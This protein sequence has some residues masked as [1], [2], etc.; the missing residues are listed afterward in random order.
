MTAWISS[1]RE[2]AAARAPY[3][4]LTIAPLWERF[5]L[6]EGMLLA[7]NAAILWFVP[8]ARG[9]AVA[10]VALST[11]V[12]AVLYALNDLV[13]CEA[14][15][16]N[17]KKKQRLVEAFVEHRRGYA[18]F[19]AAAHAA[20][21]ALGLAIGLRVGL[22]VATMLA[23]NACYSLRAK[24]TPGLDL[25]VVAVWGG[26]FAAIASA[27]WSICALVGLL[28][29]LMHVFQM[30]VDREVDASNRVRTSAVASGRTSWLVASAC[31]GVAVAL[32]PLLGAVW[33]ASAVLPAL[34]YRSARSTQAAWAWSRLYAG[35]VL[36]AALEASRGVS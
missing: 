11:A 31:A 33:A 25:A 35:G 15:R 23:V 9:E 29:L 22:A 12:L 16:A 27:P 32:L 2:G 8:L 1:A 3:A 20:L 4:Y 5:R 19:L 34:A 18:V 28:T 6:G 24:G 17:P 26:A 10:R 30:D 21:V 36:L 14:D 7:V 13:D